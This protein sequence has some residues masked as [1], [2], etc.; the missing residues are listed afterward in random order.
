MEPARGAAGSRFGA[1]AGDG[2]GGA[3][4]VVLRVARE[5]PVLRTAAVQEALSQAVGVLACYEVVVAVVVC[6]MFV[7]VHEVCKKRRSINWLT[8]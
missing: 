8:Q 4:H 3:V 7:K 6:F 2:D 1:A 5:E